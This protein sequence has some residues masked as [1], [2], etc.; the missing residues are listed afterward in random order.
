MSRHPHRRNSGPTVSRIGAAL[1]LLAGIWG[2][3]LFRYADS[4][5][6]TISQPNYKTDAI[7]VLTGGRGR[8]D[9]GFRLLD[10]GFGTRLLISGVFK[11]VDLKVLW[12]VNRQSSNGK[13]CCIDPGYDAEDTIGNAIEA[14]NWMTKHGFTSLRLVTSAYHMP[15]AILEFKH[16]L[17]EADIVQHPVFTVHVKQ[18]RWWAWPGTTGLIVGEYNKFLMAWVRHRLMSVFSKDT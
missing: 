3:G 9:E 4:I 7:V 13:G 2:A 1:V 6:T 5:P 16:S 11:G 14:R 18:A 15:R 10:E 8:L 17:P 12:D